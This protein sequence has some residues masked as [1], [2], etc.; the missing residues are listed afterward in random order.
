MKSPLILII[1]SSRETR[2]MYADYFR[3]HGFTVA[4]AADGTEGGRFCR[5]QR[6]DLIVTE[7]YN[8]GDWLQAIRVV[9]DDGSAPQTAIVACSTLI[10]S[11]KPCAP[12]GL[13]I[14]SAMGKP[15]SPRSLLAEVQRLLGLVPSAVSRPLGQT[16]GT[17]TV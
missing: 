5:E 1:D 15:T 8:E 11:S 3:Y 17:A 9:R 6:P 10:D 12:A 16:W 2:T 14:D 4:E 13:G 7:L